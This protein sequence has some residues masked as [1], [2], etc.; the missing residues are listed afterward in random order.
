MT[1]SSLEYVNSLPKKS[2]SPL[3]LT[4]NRCKFSDANN[5][6]HNRMNVVCIN[7][8]PALNF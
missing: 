2:N 7:F 4:L 8:Q 5:N 3:P 6:S 1:T